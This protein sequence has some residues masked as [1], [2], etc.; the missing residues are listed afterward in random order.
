MFGVPLRYGFS[1]IRLKSITAFHANPRL[2]MRSISTTLHR[3]LDLVTVAVFALAPVSL[4][5]SGVPMRLAYFLAMAH[6]LVTQLT[7]FSYA[8]RP[9]PL[10]LH[11]AIEGVVGVVLIALAWGLHWHGAP[12]AF[13]TVAG[14]AILVMAALTAAS[15]WQS[16]DERRV[17]ARSAHSS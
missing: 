15:Q 4:R 16:P 11:G 6:L 1:S 10:W 2:F 17:E 12:K 5:F 14:A 3:Q 8:P 9:L 7:R 13:Y